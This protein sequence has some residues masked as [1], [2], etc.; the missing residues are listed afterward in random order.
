[1]QTV[2]CFRMR[3]AIS[4]LA[5]L[6]ACA[7]LAE[8]T[9]SP[10][11]LSEDGDF[12]S[13]SNGIVSVRIRKS[14]GDLQSMAYRGTE[15]L[16]DQSGRPGGYW[17]HNTAGGAAHETRITIDP[18]VN[19]GERAEVS[20]KGISGGVNMGHGPG[21]G[22]DGD[23]PADIEIRYSLGRGESIE[24][25]ELRWTP[26]RYGKQLW[27]IG[28]PN[29]TATEFAGAARFF[30]PDISRLYAADF[31]DDVTF[32]VGDSLEADD[33]FFAHV[34]HAVSED[35]REGRATPYTISFALDQ[36]PTGTAVLRLALSG[37]G[38]P[39]L[40]VDVNGRTAGRVDLGPGDGVIARHQIQGIWRERDFRFPASL[41]REG[42]NTLT[43]TV[44][45]G[46]LTAGVVYDYL[47]LEL[48]TR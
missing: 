9:H 40:E 33:W 10:V 4:V 3:V 39:G 15:L 7:S 2:R 35:S 11:A 37:T 30:E 27:D 16:T 42:D 24:L 26:V 17:S 23:F 38:T 48:A 44:P 25:G 47:R 8:T 28:I 12:F 32:T 31:P 45:E 5:L 34:P 6:A 20:I 46:R 14:D 1:M 29:R 43:L 18:A 21:A 36:A 13:M 22:P 41:L 19:G